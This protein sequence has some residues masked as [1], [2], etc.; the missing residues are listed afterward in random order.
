MNMGEGGEIWGK[1]GE[2]SQVGRGWGDNRENEGSRVG[3]E[4]S[5]RL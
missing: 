2:W 4:L 3:S 1:K 5:G